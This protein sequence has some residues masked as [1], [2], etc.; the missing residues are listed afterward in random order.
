MN[1]KS[2]LKTASMICAV[3]TLFAGP[4]SSANAS[5]VVTPSDDANALANA[6]LGTGITLVGAPT[7]IGEPTQS[8]TFTGGTDPGVGLGIAEGIILTSGNALLAPRANTNDG[9]G[10]SLG[11]PGDPD[12]DNQINNTTNDAASL[13]FTFQFGDGSVGGDLFFD[14][15]FASEEYNEFV[16]QFNDPFALIINGINVALAPDGSTVSVNN[17]NCGNP[18]AGAGPNCG[19]Y[20]NNDPDDPGPPDFDIE[21]DGFTD[22]FTAEVLGLGAGT[23]TAK[24]VIADALD[25]QLDSAVFIAGESFASQPPDPSP[26]PE[27]ATFALFGTGLAALGLLTRRQR[28]Q[29]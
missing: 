21:Y 2:R 5:L 22:V 10:A 20:N 7:Y 9:A 29:A 3:A 24:C 27:P 17:V 23:H 19:S 11:T 26:L 1:W 12:L 16:D 6:I 14:F 28:K 25:L 4:I 8:G 13:E 18:F 15:V